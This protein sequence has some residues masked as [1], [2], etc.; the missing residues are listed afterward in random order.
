MEQNL[1]IFKGKKEGIYIYIKEGNFQ[2]IKKQLEEKLEK[3]KVFSKEERLNV[4]KER[5]FHQRKK[6]SLHY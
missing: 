3:A 1:V 2:S 6:K 5:N 4:L